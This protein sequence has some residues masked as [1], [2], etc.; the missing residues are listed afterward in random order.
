[1]TFLV[2]VDVLCGVCLEAGE[3]SEILILVKFGFKLFR[4]NFWL[5]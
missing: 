3:V 1:M 5:K 2:K 4:R